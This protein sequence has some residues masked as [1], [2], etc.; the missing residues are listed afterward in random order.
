MLT[1]SA[2]S[3]HI[4]TWSTDSERTLTQSA[5]SEH[6]LTQSTDSERILTQSTDSE[7]ILT[8]STESWAVAGHDTT[9]VRLDVVVVTKPFV[10][11]TLWGRKTD[12]WHSVKFASEND[13]SRNKAN[14]T[15]QFTGKKDFAENH[16]PVSLSVT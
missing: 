4:L 3:E 14:S 8:Q 9:E 10:W 13:G 6:I 5:D 11:I 1:Q 7:P 16:T 15:R 2:D 12:K